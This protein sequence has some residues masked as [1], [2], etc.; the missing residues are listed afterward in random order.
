MTA[1]ENIEDF[2][3]VTAAEKA[4]LE[5]ADTAF[6]APDGALE[7]LWNQRNLGVGAYNAQTGYFDLGETGHFP[8]NLAAYALVKYPAMVE[9]G[10]TM[11]QYAGGDVVPQIKIG[12]ASPGSIDGMF[13][14]C[15]AEVIAI[16]HANYGFIAATNIGWTFT[17]CRRL[18]EL[19]GGITL[20]A[21]AVVNEAFRNCEALEIIKIKGLSCNISFADSPLLRMDC[22]EYMV[23]NAVN[24]SHITIT[25]HPDVY[26]RLADELIVQAAEKQI[27]F[28]TT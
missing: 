2:K 27:T 5:R 18:R 22:V 25:L 17:N 21:N 16:T 3:E 9:Y 1:H 7:M 20:Q 28:A 26:A 13:Q 8:A 4:T 23:A 10:A 24:T 11:M 15:S 6:V 14:G 12:K 19:V